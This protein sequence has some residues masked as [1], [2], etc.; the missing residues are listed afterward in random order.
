MTMIHTFFSTKGSELHAFTG[1]SDGRRLPAQHGPWTHVGSVSANRTLPHG[2]DRKAV[3][4]AI[5]AHGFQMWRLR[6]QAD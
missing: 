5:A 3:E 4:A 6:K 2:V 1:D